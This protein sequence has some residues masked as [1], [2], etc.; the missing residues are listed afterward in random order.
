MENGFGVAMST[1]DVAARFKLFAEISVVIDLA[2]ER[3][4]QR[5]VFVCHRLMAGRHIDDAQTAVTQTDVPV[6]KETGVIR[7]AMGD[8]ITHALEQADV[9]GRVRSA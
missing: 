7:P 5:L 6:E 3:Y 2:I 9:H 8:H 1:V 4:V